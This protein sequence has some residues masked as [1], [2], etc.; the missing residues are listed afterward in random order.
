MTDKTTAFDITNVTGNPGGTSFLVATGGG[1]FLVDTGLSFSADATAEN[2]RAA[3]AGRGLDYILLTHSHFDHAAGT[4]TIARA[5]PEAKV[6]ASEYAA[7]VFT[8][9]G[10]REMIR[11]LD[12]A[13][14]KFVGAE[15]GEDT[16]SELRVDM[17]VAGGDTISANDTV[18]RV[19]NTPGHTNCSMSYYFERE[20]LFAG[21]ESSGFMFGD[22]VWPSFMTSCRD[23]LA[24]IDLIE[25]LAPCHLLLPHSGLLSGEGAKAFPAHI[26]RETREKAEFILSRHHSGMDEDSIVRD[27]TREYYDGVIRA[28]G[29]QTKESFV[30]NAE[31]LIPRLIAESM[32]V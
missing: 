25:K 4:P 2:L 29:M 12:V 16:T 6:V 17:V 9:P 32:E 8:R 10:A 3:L 14:A 27:F 31:A 21:S 18:V 15:V 23:S 30:A 26:R 1:T 5:F 19:Y 28:T 24:A 11:R 7:Y 22:I 20:D 13:A